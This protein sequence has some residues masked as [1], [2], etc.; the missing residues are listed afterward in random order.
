MRKKILPLVAAF[1]FPLLIIPQESK[2][3]IRFSP[4]YTQGIGIEETHFVE[5]LIQSYLSEMG[6]LVIVFDNTP[7]SSPSGNSLTDSWTRAPDFVVSGSIYLD[8]DSRIF[9]LEI[10]NTQTRETSRTTTVHKTASDLVLKARSLVESAFS[11]PVQAAKGES[12][13][14]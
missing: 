10:H 5:T 11:S 14:D 6:E 4:F 12:D 1:F 9:T 2:P 7:L 13:N 8:R 3:V